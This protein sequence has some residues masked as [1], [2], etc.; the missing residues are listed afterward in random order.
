MCGNPSSSSISRQAGKYKTGCLLLIVDEAA[1]RAGCFLFRSEVFRPRAGFAFNCDF[2]FDCNF[3]DL[4]RDLGLDPDTDLN[5]DIELV[6]STAPADGAS[7][8]DG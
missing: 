8:K 3:F 1:S 6:V 2:A 5:R 4:D 7:G